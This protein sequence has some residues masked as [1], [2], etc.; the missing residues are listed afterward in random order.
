MD[1]YE[2]NSSVFGHS[3]FREGQMY[4]ISSILNGRDCIGI[5]PTGGGKSLC[6]QIPAMTL[7]GLTLV[8]SPLISLMNDQVAAL[9]QAGVPAFALNSSLSYHELDELRY[10]VRSGRCKLLYVSPERLEAPAFLELIDGLRLPLVAVDEAHCISQWGQDFRPSYLGISSFIKRLPRRPVV[11]AFTATATAEVREDIARLLELRSPKVLV[12]GFDRPNLFFDVIRQG[13]KSSTL[14]ELLRERRGRPGIVYCS[15][16]KN[17]ERVW[18]LLLKHGI[19]AAKYHAGMPDFERRESQDAFQFD[20]VDVMVATN[21]FGMG[22]DK[23]NVGFVIHY[24]MPLSLEA[25]YQEAGRAGRDGSSADCILLYSPSDVMTAR[26][27][28]ERDGEN[29]A[30]S[31]EERE[32][33]RR[34][35]LLK[36]SHMESY[37]SATGCLRGFILSYFGQE[38][39]ERCGSCGNCRAAYAVQDITTQAQMLL[40]CVQRIRGALG[41]SLGAGLVAQVMTGSRD[42]KVLELGLDRLSTYGLMKDSTT[43]EVREL[44]SRLIEL[45]YLNR[46]M[47]HG[48]LSLTDKAA[49]VLF[50][51]ERVEIPVRSK[52]AGQ[53]PDRAPARS[54]GRRRSRLGPVSEPVP[55]PDMPPKEF[56]ALFEQLRALRRSLAAGLGIPPYLI[57]SDATLRDM[58]RKSPSDM[59]GLLLVNGV[60]KYKAEKYGAAFLAELNK[61]AD[62]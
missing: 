21:A 48:A 50:R 55:E 37:C 44:I 13:S 59:D 58:A 23:S 56:E 33:L 42:S 45:G 60:G 2:I 36:L 6:Y 39:P 17:T 46:N 25:Y 24:N 20:R 30:L 53:P 47:R 11:A 52:R 14:L 10:D 32:K 15:T 34:I 41:Y 19:P 3:G 49:G 54:V 43:N 8:I 26:K 57:F 62:K 35:E 51:G 12:T 4:L 28:I 16:R 38:H 22:I 61:T 7:P 9:R 29:E 18:E 5:M 27:L 40:S 31:P 1:I